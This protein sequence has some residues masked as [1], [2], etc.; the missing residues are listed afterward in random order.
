MAH[1]TGIAISPPALLASL[2]ER[3]GGFVD[4][5]V[6]ALLVERVAPLADGGA[7]VLCPVT[8]R[9]QVALALGHRAALLVDAELAP[10][11]PEGRRW[12]H[13]H[14]AWA[15]A[16]VLGEVAPLRETDARR[17]AIV[18]PGAEL[19]EGVWIGPGSLIMGG[20]SVESGSVIE[21][22]AVIYPRVR[23]GRRV[24][25]G[26]GAVIGRPGFGW[27][28]GP[29]GDLRRIPQL[30][31]VSIEDDVEIGP[32][33]TVDAGT[34]GPTVIGRGARLDAHVHV[35]HNVVIGPSAIVAAQSGLAG[36]ARL[37]AGARVGGQ[38]GIADHVDVGDGAQIAAKSGVIGDI[39]RGAT[40]A[41]Y[42]AVNRTRWLRGIARMLSLGHRTR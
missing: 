8:S 28:A 41:G 37:G 17:S 14:A 22:H 25:V 27:A 35:G 7:H 23:I 36:S 4:A 6:R 29:R 18:E 21:A 33:A 26:A 15:L 11:V 31:G 10:L 1:P 2:A 34:L 42:P 39:P 12:I 24:V 16:G 5:E 32:L 9:R 20:A 38:V 40:V 13:V 19:G 30:G 3:H